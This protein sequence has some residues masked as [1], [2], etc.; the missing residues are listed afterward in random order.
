MERNTLKIKANTDNIVEF[1][2]DTPIEG[3]NA[4]GMY[5][6]YA[7]GMDG[8][9]A[10][11]F[12]T[13]TLH[14][15]LKNFT[16]GDSVNIRKEEYEAGKFGWNVIPQDGTPT[17]KAPPPSVSTPTTTQSVDART[18]DIH[19]Q[20]CLKLAVQSMDTSETLDFA[21]VKLRMEGLLGVLDNEEVKEELPF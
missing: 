7:F 10:G 4:Y 17:R 18:K 21:M 13:D 8:E 19:R 15:K 5:H 14:E 16:K 9:E 2:Y 12:A 3:T 1:L 6:L 20:V 11:L